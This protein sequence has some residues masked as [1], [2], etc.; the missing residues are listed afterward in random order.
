MRRPAVVKGSLVKR[1]PAGAKASVLPRPARRSELNA[2]EATEEEASC[3][4]SCSSELNAVEATEEEASCYD[5]YRR[6]S[7]LYG[8]EHVDDAFDAACNYWTCYWPRRRICFR[9]LQ[10]MLNSS[11]TG[12]DFPCSLRRLVWSFI[13]GPELFVVC[14]TSLHP[15]PQLDIISIHRCLLSATAAAKHF[16]NQ[17]KRKVG[18]YRMELQTCDVPFALHASGQHGDEIAIVVSSHECFATG[19]AHVII[20]APAR[21]AHGGDGIA[22]GGCE[23]C[24]SKVVDGSKVDQQARSAFQD[25]D[26]VSA[27]DRQKVSTDI[28]FGSSFGETHLHSPLLGRSGLLRNGD[29]PSSAG[30][31]AYH[32]PSVWQRLGRSGLLYDVLSVWAETRDGKDNLALRCRY[33]AYPGPY[34]MLYEN[35]I[36]VYVERH[37]IA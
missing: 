37:A 17:K 33:Y 13:H 11:P 26:C 6:R 19:S 36:T 30:Y 12:K 31:E 3:N 7:K 34:D 15:H 21:P 9:G 18:K 14:E 20:Q 22:A 27:L 16:W 25:L 28:L 35:E 1:R 4:D 10:T 2:V 5:S 24:I 29:R 8:L 32:V 23:L